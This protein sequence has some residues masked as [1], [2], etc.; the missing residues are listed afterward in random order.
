MAT[1]QTI[2]PE[3][4]WESDR[5]LFA[6]DA[7]GGPRIEGAVLSGRAAAQRLIAN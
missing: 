4:Y 5:L 3:R 7:F 6:G 1:P 2:W